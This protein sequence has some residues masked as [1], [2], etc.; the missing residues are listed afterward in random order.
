[1]YTDWTPD[2]TWFF[3]SFQSIL[4]LSVMNAT[5]QLRDMLLVHV[6]NVLWSVDERSESTSLRESRMPHKKA[7]YTA[8]NVS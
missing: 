6:C 8:S 3:R 7:K 1:M 2:N 4:I 5:R